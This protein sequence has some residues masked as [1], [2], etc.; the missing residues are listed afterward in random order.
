MKVTNQLNPTGE[1]LK[2]FF[3]EGEDGPFAMLNM[4]KFRERAE[5]DDGDRGLSG[6]EAYALY[7]HAVIKLL[8]AR[9]GRQIYAG[10][11][12]GLMIGEVEDNWDM[13]AVIEYPSLE[14]FRDMVQSAEYQE[15]A[16][17]R[18]AGLEGQL[19]IKTKAGSL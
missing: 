15:A 11:V 1:H 19:N 17:H 3:G 18:E 16:V 8:I 13:V 2:A 10:A 7:G 9:G 4:L 6:A 5:Y 14:A 12:T